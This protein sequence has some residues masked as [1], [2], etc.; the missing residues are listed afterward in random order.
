MSNEPDPPR[1][2]IPVIECCHTV[3][4]SC[5]LIVGGVRPESLRNFRFPSTPEG[6]AAT[7][8]LSIMA[9][10][11]LPPSQSALSLGF[12]SSKAGDSTSAVI[13]RFGLEALE[14]SA[15]PLPTSHLQ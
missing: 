14:Q 1:Y 3:L 7:P 11:T 10:G 12:P 9:P 15:L 13:A 2:I 8:W 5:Q 4:L 6:R